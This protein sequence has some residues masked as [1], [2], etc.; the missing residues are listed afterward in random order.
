ML[1]RRHLLDQAYER[2]LD[3]AVLRAAGSALMHLRVSQDLCVFRNDWLSTIMIMHAACL[4]CYGWGR[5]PAW[6]MQA[7]D[8]GVLRRCAR[9]NCLGTEA[10]EGIYITRVGL[11][12]SLLLYAEV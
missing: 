4:G 10:M 9:R 7:V 12:L 8:K 1:V 11:F 2:V 5:Y 3:V 6:I